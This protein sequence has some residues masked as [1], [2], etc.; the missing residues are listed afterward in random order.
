[1]FQA[2]SSLL[3]CL[4]TID[5]RLDV[6]GGSV[7]YYATHGL[8]QGISKLC[9]SILFGVLPYLPSFLSSSPSGGS[10][11][12]LFGGTCG[13]RGRNKR[14]LSRKAISLRRPQ[15]RLK[16]VTINECSSGRHQRRIDPSFLPALFPVLSPFPSLSPSVDP[17]ASSNPSVDPSASP[18][19][20]NNPSPSPMC[21]QLIPF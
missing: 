9:T 19:P 11:R 18:S 20:S 7:A 5:I 12:P 1:M 14:G 2:C 3:S 10:P 21:L 17:S 6:I 15:R 13:P 16:H 4:S 8:A